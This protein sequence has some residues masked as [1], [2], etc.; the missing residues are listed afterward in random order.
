MLFKSISFI[1]ELLLLMIDQKLKF[2]NA[3]IKLLIFMPNIRSK[4]K[5]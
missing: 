4:M 3:Y 5:I 1:I 2:A